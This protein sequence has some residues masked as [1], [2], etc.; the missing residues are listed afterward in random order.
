MKRSPSPPPRAVEK[1][2]KPGDWVTRQEFFRRHKP[3]RKGDNRQRALIANLPKGI[4]V[5]MGLS[6]PRSRDGKCLVGYFVRIGKRFSGQKPV[7]RF[8]RDTAEA[9]DVIAGLKPHA[10]LMRV[11]QL[12]P[13]QISETIACL[14][15]L[16]ERKS[17]LSLGDA[18][19]LALRYHDPAAGR[20]TVS[21][22]ATMLSGRAKKRG[23]RRHAVAQMKSLLR[24]FEREFGSRLI[25]T[26]TTTELEDWLDDGEWSARTRNNYIKQ[27]KQ[28]YVFAIKKNFANANPAEAIDRSHVT[29]TTNDVLTPDQLR[30]LLQTARLS[31]PDLIRFIALC[32][33]GWIRRSE[34]CSLE[35]DQIRDDGFIH[36]PGPVAK[37]RQ[38]RFVPINDTLA[39]WLAVAPE[40]SRPTRS[41]N[42]DVMGDRLASLAA[43]AKVE[44]PH[45]A[46][47]HSAISYAFAYAPTRNGASMNN[48]AGE[49]A[50]Y[51]GNSEQVIVR[52]YRSLVTEKAAKDYWAILP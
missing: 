36:V 32:A 24:G 45:N 27:I 49:L 20:K 15:A 44:I 31:A 13:Q 7:R 14:R 47:R 50:K 6:G 8:V 4:S 16:G 52:S 18:V 25:T 39:A 48:S 11:S 10:E 35:N 5:F 12:S 21:E 42:A 46:L 26:L 33:F 19:D 51:A 9:R 43:D 1:A 40:A 34:V 38:N 3:S 17:D 41:K 37:T 22:V 2:I 29:S 30:L 28:L 23:G